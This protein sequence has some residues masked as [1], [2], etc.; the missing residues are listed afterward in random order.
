[1]PEWQQAAVARAERQQQRQGLIL[2]G[3]IVLAVG[4]AI[5]VYEAL[6]LTYR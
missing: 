1:M 5:I 2:W 4:V 3:L 6:G